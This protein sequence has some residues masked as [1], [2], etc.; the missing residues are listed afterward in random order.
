MEDTV[1][2]KKNIHK[3]IALT[4][5]QIELIFNH[6]KEFVSSKLDRSEATDNKSLVKEFRDCLSKYN[7][8]IAQQKTYEILSMLLG[9]KNYNIAL[10]KQ[11][12]FSSLF[13][14][15]KPFTL[16]LSDFLGEIKESSTMSLKDFQILQ[17]SISLDYS[18]RIPTGIKPLDEDLV[19]GLSPGELTTIIAGTNVGKSLFC[20]S[21][22]ANALRVEKKVLHIN[23]EGIRE[24]ALLRY[25]A[26]LSNIEYSKI[27]KNSLS[28]E[29]QNTINSLTN[30]YSDKLRIRNMIGF[31]ATIEDLYSYCIEE[32]KSFNFDMIIVDFGQLL[33][34]KE[35]EE[36]YRHTMAKVFRGLDSL[37][38]R[39]N[40]VVITPAQ[41]TR[42][43]KEREEDSIIRSA[44]ISEAF[45]IARVSS[46]IISL[47]VSEKE[48][49]ESKMRVF[50][51]KSKSAKNKL[52]SII[53]NYSKCNLISLN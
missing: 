16:P 6:M 29:E 20:V 19:G 3:Y 4:P 8:K 35:K 39:F 46:V 45:E 13:I 40:C 26:N 41:V 12:N 51:E 53:T 14:E 7:I 33:N 34:T 44:D 31:G 27:V 30:K 2:F 9:N 52:Y 38:K 28:L 25:V 47:N 24:E 10:S 22:G 36:S 37:A 49:Q 42:S 5:E 15:S 23:L 48:S 50:L 43:S 17:P 32:Y 11:I 18:L 21:L 1:S